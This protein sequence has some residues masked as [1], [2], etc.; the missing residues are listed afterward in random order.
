[1]VTI[2]TARCDIIMH[3]LLDLQII[4]VLSVYSYNV[5][6]EKIKPYFVKV[7]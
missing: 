6:A 5:L 7:N 3:L 1:M 2:S 4:C